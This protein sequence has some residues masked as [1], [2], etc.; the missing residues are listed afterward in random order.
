MLIGSWSICYGLP[1]CIFLRFLCAR[2]NVCTY[3][4]VLIC[5]LCFFF[6]FCLFCLSLNYLFLFDLTLS[7]CY[8]LDACL[9]SDERE[10]KVWIWVE[11]EVG[12]TGRGKAT[13]CFIKKNDFQ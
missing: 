1:F 12:E 2:V 9:F 7:Y 3:T 11:V 8:Y 10:K 5:F 13:G 6:V 4:Y